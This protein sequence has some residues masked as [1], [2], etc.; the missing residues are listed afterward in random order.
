MATRTSKLKAIN[1]LRW[2]YRKVDIVFGQGRVARDQR[3]VL[4]GDIMRN[5]A[6]GT[7]WEFQYR[8]GDVLRG[9][10]IEL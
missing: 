1:P 9:Y 10:P 7:L 2:G 4:T 3:W 8:E 5:E 6:D